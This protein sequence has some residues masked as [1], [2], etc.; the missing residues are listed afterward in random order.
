[1]L[2]TGQPNFSKGVIAEELVARIDVASYASGLKRA[3]NVIVLKYGGVTKRPG[4]R[5]V[6]EV[7][8]D[9]GARSVRL[10]PFQFSIEQTYALEMGQGYMRPAASGG[11]VT[12]EK[13]SIT[14]VTLGATTT[15]AAAYHAYAVGDQVFFEGV[16][17][18]IELNGKIGRVLSSAG[19]HFVV[20]IDSRGFSP[21]TGDTGGI[22]RSGPPPSPP[23]APPVPPPP[24]PPPP[25]DTGGSGG[26]VGDDGRYNPRYDDGSY[27]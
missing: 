24:P 6:A 2:R 5:L 14:D 26:G 9:R 1:M 21:F 13:L 8:D 10:M 20:D 22:T 15:I 17:G 16:E 3:D 12:E 27:M 18:T 11:M 7:H 25:P 19:D 23:T 4:T